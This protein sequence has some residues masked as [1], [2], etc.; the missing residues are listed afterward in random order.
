MQLNVGTVGPWEHTGNL[1]VGYGAFNHVVS[2]FF[3]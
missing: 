1:W 2:R 3:D